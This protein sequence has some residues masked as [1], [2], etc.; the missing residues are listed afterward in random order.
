[1]R[2]G[3]ASQ[4]LPAYARRMFRRLVARLGHRRWFSAIGSGLLPR[5]DRA[6][7]RASGHRWMVAT[8]AF[9][10]LMLHDGGHKP[11]PLLYARDGKDYLVAATNWGRPQHPA[12]SRRLL[13]GQPATVELHG[14]VTRVLARH[15]SPTEAAAA[16]PR[17]VAVWPAFD[18][19]R[20]RAEREIRVFRLSPAEDPTVP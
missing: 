8:I 15:L 6:V 3:L 20:Q 10:T 16:W 13:A 14:R 4:A 11:V 1:M 5:L 12:W 7:Y 19:Y 18:A 9:P 2:A 17:L